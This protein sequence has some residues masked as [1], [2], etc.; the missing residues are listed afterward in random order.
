MAR[1]RRP[2]ARHPLHRT[3]AAVVVVALLALLTFTTYVVRQ[4]TDAVGSQARGRVSDAATLGARVVSEQALR[5]QEVVALAGAGLPPLPDEPGAD[6]SRAAARELGI[7]ARLDALR[8]ETRGV[9]S[10]LL[11]DAR[12]R[13]VAS[14]PPDSARRRTVVTGRPWFEGARAAPVGRSVTSDAYVGLTTGRQVTAASIALRTAAGRPRAVLALTQST[15]TQAVADRSRIAGATLTVVDGSGTIVART[16]WGPRTRLTQLPDDPLVRAAREGA[17]APVRRGEGAADRISAAARVAGTSWVVLVEVPSHRALAGARSLRT[18][19]LLG[20][21]LVALALVVVVPLV[22]GHV[23]RL[24]ERV[25][26][27]DRFQEDLLPGRLP[28]GVLATS[29]PAQRGLLV[30]GDFVDA[31]QRPDG[32]LALVVGD[33][34]GHGPRAAALATR[35]RAGWR[36][37]ATTGDTVARLDALDAL[38]VAER[39]DED[40]YAT[41]VAV[42]VDPAAGRL[43]WALAGHPAA[44][45]RDGSGAVRALEGA[46][47]PA[48]GFGELGDPVASEGS[49]DLPEGWVLV[50]C[51]DGLLEAPAPGGGRLGNEPVEAALRTADGPGA[52]LAALRALAGASPTDDVTVLVASAAEGGGSGDRTTR[53]EDGER[54]P[55]PGASTTWSSSATSREAPSSSPTRS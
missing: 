45:L 34:S 18:A 50:L 16:G 39:P 25:G 4:G 22:L 14:S 47:R 36:T 26:L 2:E 52:A 53:S 20:A 10:V 51:S 42:E 40:L 29:V 37:L 1:R 32:T 46:R 43:R 23:G 49:A 28:P 33:V 41:A 7:T 48:L 38:V 30:G 11:A 54:A 44:L 5:F 21:I 35:L 3:T 17:T 9:Q 13:V 27:A 8:A 19:L 6:A 31:V 15:R 24:S 12:G 55:G